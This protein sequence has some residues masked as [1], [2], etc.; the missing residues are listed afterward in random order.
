MLSTF[1]LAGFKAQIKKM[2]DK[3]R[4]IASIMV[5]GCFVLILIFGF[6]VK[7]AVLCIILLIVQFVGLFWYV[8]SMIPGF[9][10]FFCCCCRVIKNGAAT[11][12]V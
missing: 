4:R 10:K 5:L 2:F 12:G 7:N 1:F 9:K 8:S 6:A 3:E 11:S